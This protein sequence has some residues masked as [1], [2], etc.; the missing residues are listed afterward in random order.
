[1]DQHVDGPF[2]GDSREEES[3]KMKGFRIEPPLSMVL[4]PILA[5]ESLL[6]K[7]T[8]LINMEFKQLQ[9]LCRETKYVR[10]FYT[11]AVLEMG[12]PSIND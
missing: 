9:F 5:Y 4:R 12:P 3:C 2:L 10:H 11:N 7:P 8:S 1:M 6:A